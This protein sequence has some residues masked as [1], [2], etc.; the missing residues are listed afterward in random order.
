MEKWEFISGSALSVPG[1]DDQSKYLVTGSFRDRFAWDGAA[2]SNGLSFFTRTTYSYIGKY[3]ATLTFR[4]DASSKYQEKWGFFPSIG[5]GWV[6]TEESFMQNQDIFTNLKIRASW[7]LMGNDNVPANSE[8]ALGQT[9]AASSAVFGDRLVD[10]VGSQTVLQNFLEWEVVNEYDIGVDFAIGDNFSGGLDYYHRI[11]DNVVFFAPIATGG[12]IAELLGNNGSV[13]NSG[14]E[15]SLSW[16]DKLS[17]RSDY[18]LG[19]NA[20]TI[21][22]RVLKLQGRDNLSGETTRRGLNQANP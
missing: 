9:G 22:N 14:F 12:G 2:S 18:R 15:L 6:L 16:T 4:A 3:L 21:H 8:V 7:G 1:I 10:G 19:L 5:V 17:E 13:L 11:T 20:T